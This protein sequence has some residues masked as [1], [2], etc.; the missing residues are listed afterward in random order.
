MKSSHHHA[1]RRTGGAGHSG[2]ANAGPGGR[3]G[4][5]ACAGAGLNRAELLQ[6]M[7][8][9]PA[10]PGAPENIPGLEF[11]ARWTP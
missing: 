4:A 10:P 5:R 9:Y 1:P 11:A 8:L 6:R 3:A 2:G 7:G